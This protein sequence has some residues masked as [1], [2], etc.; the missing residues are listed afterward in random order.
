[1]LYV[2]DKKLRTILN[3]TNCRVCLLTNFVGNRP[4][5]KKKTVRLRFFSVREWYN[6]TLLSIK[7]KCANTNLLKY[8]SIMSNT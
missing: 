3:I 2:L 7:C 1:M 5:M 6:I 8:L 4:K